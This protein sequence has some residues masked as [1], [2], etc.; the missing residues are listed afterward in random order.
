M[1]CTNC[2]CH[3]FA[4]TTL[5]NEADMATSFLCNLLAFLESK[6]RDYFRWTFLFLGHTWALILRYIKD[7][8]LACMTENKLSSKRKKCDL[9]VDWTIPPSSWIKL[10]IDRASKGNLN[11]ALI[12]GLLHNEWG[13]WLAGLCKPW[14][15]VLCLKQNFEACI[16]VSKWVSYWTFVNLLWR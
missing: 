13:S 8:L 7:I 11:L 2:C 14:E 12:G 3:L 1:I 4:S 15:C 9:F 6:K 16:W 10:N 5:V